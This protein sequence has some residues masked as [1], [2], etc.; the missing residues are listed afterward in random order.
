MGEDDMTQALTIGQMQT[1]QNA[2]QTRL[3]LVFD[4]LPIGMLVVDINTQLSQANKALQDMLGYDAE[5]LVR[6]DMRSLVP[7]DDR[8]LCDALCTELVS[9]KRDSYQVETRYLHKDGHDVWCK[10]DVSLVRDALGKPQLA[11]A[12]MEDISVRKRFDASSKR[13]IR[14]DE[15]VLNAAGWGV[16][17]VDRY[18]SIVFV[19]PVAARMLGWNIDDLIGHPV[20]VIHQAHATAI[21]WQQ[22]ERP[23]YGALRDGLTRHCE[24]DI[25]FDKHGSSFPVEYTVT[26][27]IEDGAASGVAIT[28]R[29]IRTG[30]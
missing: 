18:G 15:L 11:I 20:W 6:I 9:G 14:R 24:H 7:L 30:F 17:E 1:A 2:L 12:L 3:Q 28:F 27:I 25:F 4:H 22:D 26:P 16:C 8:A 21:I 5:E 13:L 10:S 29:S 19:N 23:I